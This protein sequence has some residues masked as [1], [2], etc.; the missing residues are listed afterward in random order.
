MYLTLFQAG[1]SSMS[2][3]LFKDE[4]VAAAY[5]KTRLKPP[6]S[7]VRSIL[8]YLHSGV[9]NRRCFIKF[10]LFAPYRHSGEIPVHSYLQ[11]ATLPPAWW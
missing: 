10:W 8:D 6:A 7:L 11:P 4:N 5:A 1:K 2:Q 9:S 3:Q